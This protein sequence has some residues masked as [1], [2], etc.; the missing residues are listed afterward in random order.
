MGIITETVER[1]QRFHQGCLISS[2]GYRRL[3]RR[4]VN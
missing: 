3:L 2:I 4:S 1:R